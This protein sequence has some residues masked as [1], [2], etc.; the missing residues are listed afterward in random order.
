M[1]NELFDISFDS[2]SDSE[3]DI[4][5]PTK[6]IVE[7]TPEDKQKNIQETKKQKIEINKDKEEEDE[8][9]IDIDDINDSST[10]ETGKN[11]DTSES[12]SSEADSSPITPFASLLHERGFL[13][14]LDMEE[15]KKSED[16]IEALAEA[17]KKE[18]ELRM[19]MLVNSFPE[20]L[21]D[22]A[23]AVKEG[24]PFNE[25]KEH[26]IKELNYNSITEAQLKEESTQIKL[27]TENLKLKGFKDVKINKMID[28]YKDLGSLEEEAIDALPELKQM[29]KDHQENIKK[30]FAEQQKQLEYKH[31]EQIQ[32]IQSIV[33]QTDEI[34]PGLK[35]NDTE[36]AE[37]FK[38]MT[39]IVGQDSQG[40]PMNLV[41][42][43]RI[44]DPVKFDMAVTYLAKTTKG[45]TDWSRINK[46]AKTSAVKDFE[47]ALQSTVVKT[48][49]SRKQSYNQ[50]T[51]DTVNSLKKL[52]KIQ[53]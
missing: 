52:F 1:A 5:D 33:K 8:S 3:I 53:Y 14:N 47:K 4:G 44:K 2:I 9:L 13:P 28:T 10:D 49:V 40:N 17:F 35:L 15:F 50:S 46:T 39:Q 34:V 25:L 48:G 51:D 11:E 27:I 38:N 6:K 45:F 12:S 43:M 22:M 26:K 7:E 31:K 37:L 42:Q 36:K 19:E 24:I 29:V 30:Q 32:E 21:I 18:D 23:K 41:M 16:P 20:E